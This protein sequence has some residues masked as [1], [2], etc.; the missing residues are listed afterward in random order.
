MLK[1]KLMEIKLREKLDRYD[2]AVKKQTTKLKALNVEDADIEEFLKE[3]NLRIKTL[4][5]EIKSAEAQLAEA[6][7]TEAEKKNDYD[8]AIALLKTVGDRN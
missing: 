8:K 2:A 7:K 1:A 6:T 4:K 3:L 5:G